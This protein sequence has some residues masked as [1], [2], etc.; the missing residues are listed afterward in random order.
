MENNKDQFSHFDKLFSRTSADAGVMARLGCTARCFWCSALCWG[1]RGHEAD[2]DEIRKHHS[3]H[4]PRGLIGTCEKF[5]HHLL[6]RPCH[7]TPDDNMVCFGD[8]TWTAESNGKWRRK[9]ISVTGS[10]TD[11]TIQGSMNLCDGFSLSCITTLRN[12]MSH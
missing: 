8:Y 10:L 1:Q 2:Q 12:V 11:I 7:D 4:Q 3:T 5:T 9:S 6:A